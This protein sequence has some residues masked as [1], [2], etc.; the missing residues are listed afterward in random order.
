MLSALG[1]TDGATTR[2]TRW[3]PD[4]PPTPLWGAPGQT[5]PDQITVAV[6]YEAVVDLIEPLRLVAAL[7]SDQQPAIDAAIY[8]SGA[9]HLPRRGARR[10]QHG[11]GVGPGRHRLALRS[12]GTHP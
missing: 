2:T 11:N 7:C 10:A 12:R 5:T 6:P 9:G 4:E 1:A 3:R 8:S